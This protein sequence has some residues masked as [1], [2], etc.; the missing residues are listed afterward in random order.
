[1]KEHLAIVLDEHGGTAGLVTM[2]DLLE[3]IVGEI[4]DEY[5][6]P[7]APDAPTV[8]GEVQ[9]AG[10]THIGELN[11]R[12]GLS[13]PD[14][15]HTTIGG[16]IFGMLGRLPIPGDR[17]SSGGALFTVVAM[18]GRRIDTVAVDLHT[19]GDRRADVREPT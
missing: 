4:L 17:V 10:S 7:L 9:I 8:G 19:A 15:E 11:D 6:D 16:V 13:V 18:A 2:E 5:D 1:L 12:F 3:E 14:M